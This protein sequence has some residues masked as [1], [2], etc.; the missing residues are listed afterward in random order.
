MTAHALVACAMFLLAAAPACAAMPEERLPADA[1]DAAVFSVEEGTGHLLIAAKSGG[2]LLLQ[3]AE[4][5]I[6]V[7]LLAGMAATTADGGFVVSAWER[8]LGAYE[9]TQGLFKDLPYRIV[10]EPGHSQ[11]GFEL[12]LRRHPWLVLMEDPPPG[13]RVE[14]IES[15]ARLRAE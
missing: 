8:V 1:I 12:T 14:L 15:G 3:E 4:R 6:L 9:H 7:G 2:T 11:R 10:V 13:W 5:E